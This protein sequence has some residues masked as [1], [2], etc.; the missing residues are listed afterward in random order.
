[1]QDINPGMALFLFNYHD[2]KLHGVFEAS[3]TGDLDIDPHAWTGA[4][5]R[6]RRDA[7]RFPAQ[8]CLYLLLSTSSGCVPAISVAPY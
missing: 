8:V 2:K 3:S 5:G 4:A 1:M 7:T 6:A